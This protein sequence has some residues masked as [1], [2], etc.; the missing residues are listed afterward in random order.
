MNYDEY[1]KSRKEIV[2]NFVDI[3]FD[4]SKDHTFD[5]NEEEKAK[6]EE[7]GRKMN[8]LAKELESDLEELKSHTRYE[9]D[10]KSQYQI[11]GD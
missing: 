2:H 8:N 6:Y 5:M 9:N 3:L 4:E 10:E 1:L 11:M 7:V